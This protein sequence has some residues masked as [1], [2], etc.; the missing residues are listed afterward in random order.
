[1][2]ACARTRDSWAPRPSTGKWQPPPPAP[3]PAP[4]RAVVHN[5]LTHN[6]QGLL[7]HTM[8]LL[9]AAQGGAPSL[10]A[11]NALHLVGSLAK[12]ASEMAAPSTLAALFDTPPAAPEALQGALGRGAGAEP[13]A[14]DCWAAPHTALGLASVLSAATKP[15]RLPP[16]LALP[17]GQRTLM[18]AFT[19]RVVAM[20]ASCKPRCG[21]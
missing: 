5:P 2:A 4:R 10:P 12:G 21:G 19:G 14:D 6:C 20:L 18:P 16:P 11:A 8:E 7:L 9:A 13:A 15:A 1:M 3:P 17:P